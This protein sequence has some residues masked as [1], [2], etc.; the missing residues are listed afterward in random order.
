MRACQHPAASPL[1][2]CGAQHS[3]SLSCSELLHVARNGCALQATLCTP[4]AERVRQTFLDFFKSKQHTEVPSSSVV[5]HQDPT[6]LFANA[7]MNQFKSIFLGTTDPAS[8]LARLTRA[9]DSQKVL[10]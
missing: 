6:L 4:A 7:G 1:V 2:V 8:H 10:T 9:C 5:P 3:S